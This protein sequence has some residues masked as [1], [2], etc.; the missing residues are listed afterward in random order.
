MNRSTPRW[1]VT[2]FVA[3]LT[4]AALSG[5]NDV[6]RQNA[7][8]ADKGGHSMTSATPGPPPE[9][10]VREAIPQS[11]EQAQDTVVGYL[12]RTL[13]PLPPGTVIDGSRYLGP[14]VTAYCDDNDSSP[15]APR[16]FDTIG[17]LS[18]P[19]GSESVDLIAKVGETWRSWGWYVVERDGF[20]KPNR[21]GYAPDGYRLQ[22]ETASQQG[23]PPAIQGSSPCFPGTIAREG[24]PIPV[25]I[26]A[27]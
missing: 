13:T 3:A 26:R 6:H 8:P 17:E 21:F 12:R 25:V 10:K 18:L 15:T 7:Q 16:R 22:I 4:A 27:E 2:I 20:T 24:I 11:Q 5:C 9:W 19:P 23:Y 1:R 14:G